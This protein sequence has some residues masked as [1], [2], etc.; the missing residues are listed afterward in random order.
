MRVHPRGSLV[1]L[2]FVAL[3]TLGLQLR[4]VIPAAMAVGVI[5]WLALG[6]LLIPRR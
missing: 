3:L 5:D 4:W 6:G 2:A 1:L